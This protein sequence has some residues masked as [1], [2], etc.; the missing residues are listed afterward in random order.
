VY[1]PIL[2]NPGKCSMM[3]GADC[4]STNQERVKEILNVDNSA[5]EDKYLGLP[6]PEGPI[7][8]QKF[9]ATKESLLKEKDREAHVDGSKKKF[10]CSDKI[11]CSGHTNICHDGNI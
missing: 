1:R 6:T 8:K 11:F 4:T 9:K 10:C 3:F 7:S 5:M 2:I